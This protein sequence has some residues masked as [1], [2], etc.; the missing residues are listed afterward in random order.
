MIDF[1]LMK[2]AQFKDGAAY[3]PICVVKLKDVN[4]DRGKPSLQLNFDSQMRSWLRTLVN[5]CPLPVLYSLSVV[6][7]RMRVYKAQG[8]TITPDA[9]PVNPR[10]C[11]PSDY[12][13]QAWQT[14][15]LH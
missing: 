10:F 12:L 4:M 6:G 11:L 5:Y 7:D 2:V 1:V 15:I 8:N 9:E 13:S 3:I 14:Q